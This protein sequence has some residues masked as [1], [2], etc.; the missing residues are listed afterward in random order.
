M[1]ITR[2]LLQTE[3]PWNPKIMVG[4]VVTRVLPESALHSL[5][6]HYYAYLLSHKL[7]VPENDQILAGLLVASGASV[8]DIGASIGGYTKF[9]SEKAGPEGHVYSF[10]P[11]PST[12]DFLSYNVAVLG[13]SN[14]E[15][16]NAAVSDV[17]GSAELR[18]PRYRWGSECHYDARLDGP[19]K[20]EWRSVTVKTGTLDS[21]LKDKKISFIKCDANFHELAV[22]RG[23]P[24]LIGR[25][26]PAML[27]EINPDP[28]N[29]A[30]SAFQ[31]FALLRAAGYE[32]YWLDGEK[33]RPRL[34]G[35]KSQNYFFLTPHH[36]DFLSTRGA[37][38]V[39]GL[40]VKL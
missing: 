4:R 21:F 11:N 34:A 28:D 10:E 7:T 2:K 15:I 19:I 14:V 1:W 9:L 18:I 16:L 25:C 8:V 24:D 35:E 12:F 33:L 3:S 20:S 5:R 31:T 32:A 27:I 39:E 40:T 13:L 38:Q 6:K 30:T 36:L 37:P 17:A 26:K 23:A 29:P 22:L